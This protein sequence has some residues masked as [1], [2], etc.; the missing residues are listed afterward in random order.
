MLVLDSYS[1]IAG[2]EE[3]A[4]TPRAI[5]NHLKSTKALRHLTVSLSI[6]SISRCQPHAPEER[7]L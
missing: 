2:N 5:S 4:L 7:A 6:L 3:L 1:A